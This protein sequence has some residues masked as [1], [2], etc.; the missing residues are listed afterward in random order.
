MMCSTLTTANTNDGPDDLALSN[1]AVNENVADGTVVGTASGSDADVGD[2]LS[3][4]LTDD[5]GGR[6]AIDSSTGEI[7]VADGS[8][9]GSRGG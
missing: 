9:P 1:A 4:S 6:F 2:V 7:T 5:A 3:Y 8:C